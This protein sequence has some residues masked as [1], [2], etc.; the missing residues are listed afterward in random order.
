[1]RE[2][3]IEF[4]EVAWPMPT[5]GLPQIGGQFRRAWIA[6]SPCRNRRCE[7]GNCGIK[8]DRPI[9][10]ETSGHPDVIALGL[11]GRQA[12]RDDHSVERST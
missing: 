7:G 6:Q 1:M 4:I 8:I 2:A 12:W 5:N 3:G 11:Q 10:A 9:E